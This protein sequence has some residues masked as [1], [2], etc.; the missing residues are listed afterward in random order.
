VIVQWGIKGLWLPDDASAE[1]IID[2]HVGIVCNWWSDTRSISQADKSKKL[3]PAALDMH[4]NHF[5]SRDPLTGRPFSEVTPFI[6]IACGTISRDMAARTNEVHSALETAL[7]YGTRFGKQNVGYLYWCWVIVGP[8]AAVEVEGVA[9]E[10]RDLN[11]YRAYSAFQNE[12]EVTAK[13]VIPVN[14]IQRC[15]KWV[16]DRAAKDFRRSWTHQNP[17]FTPPETLSNVRELI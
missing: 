14:H 5:S 4:V 12:G 10:V 8:R 3:T 2:S 1:R 16:W 9:E 7:L 17:S 11:T 13:V 6:S 15:E